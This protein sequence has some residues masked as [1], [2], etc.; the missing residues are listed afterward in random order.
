MRTYNGTITIDRFTYNFEAVIPEELIFIYSRNVYSYIKITDANGKGVEGLR[1]QQVIMGSTT[2]AGNNKEYRY[3]NKDGIVRFDS[4]HLLQMLTNTRDSE[5]SDIDYT[6]S[7]VTSWNTSRF[8]LQ[9]YVN[10]QQ[11]MSAICQYFNGSHFI[12]EDWWANERKLKF[13]SSYPFTFDFVNTEKLNVSINN[14]TSQIVTAPYI[15]SQMK[16]INRI[17]PISLGLSSSTRSVV[18]K[19]NISREFSRA[20]SSAFSIYENK[21]GWAVVDGLIDEDVENVVRLE[22]DNCPANDNRTYMRWLGKH[23]EVFYWLFYNQAEEIQASSDLYIT[24]HDDVFK[25]SETN[26]ILDN[27][28]VKDVTIKKKRTI[29]TEPVDSYYYD[30]IVQMADSPYVDMYL[31]NGK[32]Q[33]VNVQD[34]SFSKSLKG[35]ERQKKHRFVYT[36]EIGG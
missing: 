4:A 18:V 27:G 29:F 11:L 21:A 5:M 30:Y 36:I 14:G 22:V 31:G 9:F 15:A 2:M 32:W 35:A 7:N 6:A 17:S 16:M 10:G 3:T 12:A 23:G 26:K 1:V 34:A 8:S 33:R 28:V 25:G 20:F 19:S 13:W 24:S